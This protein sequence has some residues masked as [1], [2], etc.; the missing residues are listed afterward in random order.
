MNSNTSTMRKYRISL[1]EDNTVLIAS[2][3]SER[4]LSVIFDPLS[5][6]E[7]SISYSGKID[8]TFPSADVLFMRRIISARNNMGRMVHST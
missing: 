2:P 4:A 7:L 3:L 8:G 6:V 5:V 1:D